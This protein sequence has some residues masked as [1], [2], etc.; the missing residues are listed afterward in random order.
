MKIL[1]IEEHHYSIIY[2]KDGEK[3]RVYRRFNETTWQV[4]HRDQWKDIINS[5]DLE[6]L[7]KKD[8]NY[9]KGKVHK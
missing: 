1:S 2:V 3:Y 5:A 8:N 4:F 7:F 9:E 6:E